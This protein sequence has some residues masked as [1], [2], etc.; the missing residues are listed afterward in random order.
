MYT[1]IYTYRYPFTNIHIKRRLQGHHVQNVTPPPAPH[2]NLTN[3]LWASYWLPVYIYIYM[4][5][6]EQASKSASLPNKSS[7]LLAPLPPRV[8]CRAPEVWS[9]QEVGWGPDKHGG[10]YMGHNPRHPR[11]S[12]HLPHSPTRREGSV[13]R[14]KTLCVSKL[15]RA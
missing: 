1:C 4:E 15:Q 7:R 5:V 9:D 13:K 3:P 12:K 14:I 10:C 11:P 8:L 2:K 6:T